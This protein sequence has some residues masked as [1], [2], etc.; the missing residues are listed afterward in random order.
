[1]AKRKPDVDGLSPE[2]LREL[3]VREALERAEKHLTER[4][5]RPA[6][7]VVNRQ[8][9]LVYVWLDP[10]EIQGGR[11]QKLR[12][13]LTA[14]GH[15]LADQGEYVPECSTA[16]VWCTFREVSARLFEDRK[17]RNDA[18]LAKYRPNRKRQP[19]VAQNW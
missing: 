8:A 10:A 3:R 14:T 4:R 7:Q 17:R 9:D 6:G 15:W 16:E 12:D 5:D 18:A 1:M 19:L 13:K 11:L 2:E